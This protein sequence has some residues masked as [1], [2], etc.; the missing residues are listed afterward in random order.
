MGTS[1]TIR[2][3]DLGDKSWFRSET[4]Q[5]G[6]LMEELVRCL[7]CEKRIRAER[8]QKPSEAF[9]LYFGEKHGIELPPPVRHGY[10][11]LSF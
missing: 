6:V 9:A 5:I 2:A 3:I 10:R 7:I 11:P 4:C 8:P 1:L